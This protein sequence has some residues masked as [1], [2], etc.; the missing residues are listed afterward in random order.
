MSRPCFRWIPATQAILWTACLLVLFALPA[1]AQQPGPDVA[2]GRYFVA[3]KPTLT[4]DDVTTVKG[5]GIPI[6]HQFPAVRALAIAIQNQNQLA[7]LQ[8]NPNIDYIEPEPMRYG[9]GLAD[10]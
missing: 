6:L 3:F 8:N 5:L 9:T 7:A 2:P 1:G 4:G 10:A